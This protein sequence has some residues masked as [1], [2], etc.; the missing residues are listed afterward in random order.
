MEEDDDDILPILYRFKFE[1][2]SR[3]IFKVSLDTTTLEPVKPIAKFL[4]D[5][6]RLEFKQ[7]EGCPL[8]PATTPYCPAAARLYPIVEKMRDVISTEP[9]KVSV[10]TPQ[11]AVV[12][13]TSVQDG[14]S[15]LLGV[16][17]ATSGCPLTAFFRPMARFHLPFADLEETT[18]RAASTYM[19]A[20]HYRVT[21]GQTADLSLK[22]LHALYQQASE[23][24]RNLSERLRSEQREDSAVNA[25]VIL[26]MFA[27]GLP[28]Q[29]D[30]MLD[31]LGQ[32]FAPY[33]DDEPAQTQPQQKTG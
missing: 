22:G 28:P 27:K 4:P 24:N 7:C 3:L 30:S 20:Q 14:L 31:E 2:D 25:I 1:D 11:R 18:Y 23:V 19:L 15:S 13:Q 26:D 9:V 10:A 32:S 29:F 17:L 21:Q 5:W 12:R 8:N 33:L 6:A 16:T